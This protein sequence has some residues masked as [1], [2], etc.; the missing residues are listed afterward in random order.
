MHE[1]DLGG[2]AIALVLVVQRGSGSAEAGD[3][4]VVLPD[5]WIVNPPRGAETMTGTMPQGMAVSPDGSIIAVVESGYNPPTIGLYRVPDLTRLAS[6]PLPGADGRPLWRDAG[7]VLVAGANAEALLDV[8][9]RS[10]TWRRIAF[11]KGSYPAYVACAP[12][13]KTYAVATE[14]DRAVRIG[15]LDELGRGPATLIGGRPGGLA[16]GAD[17]AS[18]FVT[19]RSGAELI[20]IRTL[21][22]ATRRIRVGLHPSAI[23]VADG[24]VYV[25]ETDADALGVYDANDLHELDRIALG[26]ATGSQVVGV[27]PNAIFA[28]GATIFVSLGAANSVAV[29]RSGRVAGLMEAGW[30][31]TDV[32]AIGARLYVLDG[33][34]EGARPNP[35][36]RPG[37]DR[38]YIGA[39]E[40][41]SLRAY[42]IL[43]AM[44][45]RGNPQGA[46]GWN[47]A[48]VARG[49]VRPNGPIRHVF[50]VL[51]ENRSY[52]QVLG[53][54][55]QG[56]GDASLAS[57]GGLV[58]PNDHAIAARFGLFDNAYA[59]GEVSAPG[60]MWATA[61]FAND[62]VERFWPALYGGRHKTDDLTAED[63]ADVPA[64]GY[65]WDAA[66]RSHVTFRDYGELVEA[67]TTPASPGVADAPSLN[68]HF[69]PSYRGWD[70]D[71]SDLDRVKEW[72]RE[73][74]AFV[75]AGHLPQ[76]EFIWLPGDHTHGSKAG[77]LT[78]SSYVAINDA[79]LGKMVDALSHSTVWASSVM[80]AIEDDA[81][82]GAD[83]VGDQR[84]TLYVISPYARNGVHHEHYTTVS[85]LR[86]IEIM[87]GIQ[88]LS[89][90]DAMAVPMYG[91]FGSPDMRPYTAIAPRIDITQKNLKTAYGGALSDRLD[92]SRPDATPAGV[93]EDILA[94]YQ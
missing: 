5:G 36:L 62:Y 26:D 67:A 69:D 22:R 1:A 51:K 75:R 25:A 60:H 76:F 11:P 31:P 47:S 3:G 20:A 16:F 68:G 27:S 84:T 64:G 9:V 33:K 80:F 18:A 55:S 21:S 57:F 38:D 35:Q 92:F 90:Y 71:Y 81:Q 6:I 66:R 94:H 88:P 40:F 86:T 19:L 79:A 43:D 59:G 93:L 30:Y 10:Q 61:A 53:D 83:H 2:L 7:H 12:D 17:G 13:G 63:G 49:V 52:D 32:L 78:P 45:D 65:V 28:E 89:I 73:F 70:L 8:D 39:I 14:G 85:V 4:P 44:G 42:E 58:T 34:G 74:S 87:L 91:A 48:G 15:R 82:D 29:V 46:V 50:F 54:M 24:K 23:A 72:R 37:R 77:K 41:G 56:N